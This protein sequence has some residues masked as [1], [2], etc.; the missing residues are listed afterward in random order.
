MVKE[1]RDKF[2]IFTPLRAKVADLLSPGVPDL[3]TVRECVV[4]IQLYKEEDGRYVAIMQGGGLFHIPK[5]T[6]EVAIRTFLEAPGVGKAKNILAMVA[7]AYKKILSSK[8]INSD[9]YILKEFKRLPPALLPI[10][11]HKDLHELYDQH[12][13]LFS[14]RR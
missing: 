10:M 9:G 1:N 5:I 12:P 13:V 2:L 14:Y 7:E 4:T 8:D 6:D 11:I 3:N